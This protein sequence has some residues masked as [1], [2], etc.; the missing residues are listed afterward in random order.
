MICWWRDIIG[1]NP[2]I[3]ET[4]CQ[5]A[6]QDIIE[7][8]ESCPGSS[9][10]SGT[11]LSSLSQRGNYKGGDWRTP[12]LLIS[13]GGQI[14]FSNILTNRLTV[15]KDQNSNQLNTNILSTQWIIREELY[16]CFHRP[17]MLW[18]GSV[19]NVCED[20]H[21][22]NDNDK[23]LHWSDESWTWHPHTS[24]QH[25]HGIPWQASQP[26]IVHAIYKVPVRGVLSAMNVGVAARE[27][28]ILRK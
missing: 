1:R 17:G 15:T 14:I 20:K 9:K 16:F 2:H 5:G 28:T 23:Y 27:D 11:L 10:F 19:K 24:A 12:G 25:Q 8:V 26:F 3:I 21:N 22:D 6:Q 13:A 18:P 7:A 4:P